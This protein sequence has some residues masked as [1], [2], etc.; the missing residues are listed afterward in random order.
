MP[1]QISLALAQAYD[2]SLALFADFVP[3][4][5]LPDII[6]IAIGSFLGAGLAVLFVLLRQNAARRRE[7]KA[8]G[9][10]A[11]ATLD[12]LAND[13][14]LARA[15]ILN[16]REFILR[17]RPRLPPWMHVKPA[18]FSYA[19]TLRF[20]LSALAFLLEE[21]GGVQVTKNLLAAESTYHDFF[22]LLSDYVSVAE[23]VREKFMLAGIDP[24]DAARVREF[25]EV[26]GAATVAKAERLAHAILAHVERSETVFRD[27]A[28]ALSAGLG[29]RFGKKGVGRVEVPTYTQLRKMLESS[30]DGLRTP[31]IRP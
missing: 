27:A 7:R 16:Y 30:E 2:S 6:K 13:F 22:G 14:A 12:R 19:G 24:M 8:V 18:H 5:Y 23:T 1:D 29:R 28:I 25:P 3:S 15:V 31:P 11:I 4:G 17:E 20:D 21:E 26:A 9:N 10:L